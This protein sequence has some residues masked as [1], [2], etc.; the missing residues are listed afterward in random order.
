M[1]ISWL[2]NHHLHEAPLGLST[3]DLPRQISARV[4]CWSRLHSSTTGCENQDVP[5]RQRPATVEIGHICIQIFLTL[6]NLTKQLAPASVVKNLFVK[7][8]PF[9]RLRIVNYIFVD[10]AFFAK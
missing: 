8:L 5:Q 1:R 7:K 10:I 9:S 4:H 2:F 3:L 6:C